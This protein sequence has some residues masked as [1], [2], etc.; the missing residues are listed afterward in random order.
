[1][2]QEQ[3]QIYYDRDLQLEAYHLSGIVQKFPNHFHD[4]YV[5]GFIEGGH[6]QLWCKGQTY[7]LHAGDLII[8]NPRDNHCCAPIGEEL[9][10]YRA[11]NI[12][13]QRLGEAALEITGRYFLPCFTANV[14]PQSDITHSL[15]A[16]YLAIVNQESVL[17]KEEAYFFLL[18]QLLSAWA[19]PTEERA[20][21]PTDRISQL[22]RYM[23]AHFAEP[24]TLDDFLQIA[25]CSK[26]YLLRSFTQEV[27]VSPYRYLQTIRLNQAKKWLE[28]GL[29]PV[30]AASQA[31]LSDQ[32]H[33]TH[34]FKE[35]IGLTPKQYQ[36]IYTAGASASQST[37]GAKST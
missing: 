15:R 35:F 3:R 29:A 14:L 28:Q 20:A 24:L 10:D 9:L 13:P 12:L 11:L 4:D 32:S 7:E 2:N 30:K 23:E 8:F 6:R 31:G 16:T 21:A 22:C 18:E 26:S 1:M 25:H 5:I 36:R 37:K 27:G 33:F 19:A 34:F 17:A